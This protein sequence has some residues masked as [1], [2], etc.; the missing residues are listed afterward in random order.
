MSDDNGTRGDSPFELEPEAPEPK[1]K[2]PAPLPDDPPEP[3][4]ISDVDTRT[5]AERQGEDRPVGATE[6]LA[7][8][9]D[10]P[11]EAL[12][13]PL[14]GPGPGFM[15][16]AGGLLFV[17]DMLVMFEQVRWLGWALQ[18][19]ALVF[20]LRAVFAVIGSSAA[21]RDDAYGWAKALQFEGDDLF[22]WLRT[23]IWF[24]VCLLP[25]PILI[26][27]DQVG[28]G[29]AMLVLGSMYASV[30]ALADGLGDRSQR[31]P[32]HAARWMLTR[33]ISCLVGSVGWWALVP[34][35][36]GSG[37]GYVLSALALRAAGAYL[38]LFSA[39]VLGVMGRSWTAS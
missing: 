23:V 25:G 26:A 1:R 14:R 6:A 35:R 7:N 30:V 16:F 10:W 2:L 15:L 36:D 4:D 12:S 22:P 18:L 9:P 17:F 11:R 21:G 34:Q 37:V 38:L 24:A 31:M 20:I 33:P 3:V 19:F 27:F 32:W 29:I 5:V 28:W 8:P 13:F 39:R